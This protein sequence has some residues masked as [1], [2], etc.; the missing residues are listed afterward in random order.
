MSTLVYCAGKGRTGTFVIPDSVDTVMIYAFSNCTSLSKISIGAN[1]M[2]F[3]PALDE[4]VNLTKITVSSSNSWYTAS[5]DMLYNKAKTQLLICPSGKTGNVSI[6]SGVT[7][8]AYRSFSG[9]KNLSGITLPSSVQT[10]GEYAFKDCVKLEELELPNGMESL[11]TNALTGCTGLTSIHIPATLENMQTSYW[12]DDSNLFEGCTN[13]KSITVDSGNPVYSA[14]KGILYNK[15]KTKLLAYP[16]AKAGAMKIPSSVTQIAYGAF[17]GC[18]NLTSVTVPDSVQRIGSN[19][20]SG[21]VSL[22][23]VS[24]P[25]NLTRI[26]RNAFAGCENLSDISIPSSVL[27][28]SNYAFKDC[29]KL[30][31]ISLPSNVTEVAYGTFSGCESLAT[32]TLPSSLMYIETD[33]FY[34]CKSLNNAVI[35]KSVLYIG[36]R[37]FGDCTK[38]KSVTFCGDIPSNYEMFKDTKTTAYYPKGN[39]T[40]TAALREEMGGDITWKAKARLSKPAVTA[41]YQRSSGKP[42]LSWNAISKAK[43]YDIYRASSKNGTYKKIDSTTELTYVD[44]SAEDGKTYYYKVRAVDKEPDYSSAYSKVVSQI[45]KL[46]RPVVKASNEASTGEVKLTWESISGAEKYYIYRATSKN[47]SYKLIATAKDAFYVDKNGS[48]GKAYYYRVKAVHEKTEANSALSS[49]IRAVQDMKCPTVEVKLNS[50]SQPVVE[51]EKIDGAEK[52]VIYR[53]TSKS[54]EYKKIKTT[55]DTSFKDT[56]AN[57]GKTYYYKVKAI[58]SIS[59]ANSAWSPVVKIKIS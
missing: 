19:T 11:M 56:D 53:A 12:G 58:H 47:G 4:C 10:I 2:D 23:K 22:E 9:C 41:D 57:T 36:Q 49:V 24:L 13:L 40:W 27:S 43:Q 8:I 38:L 32:V 21:C 50:A 26:D 54:G 39:D 16:L 28:I 18:W 52:Y 20:F 6:P 17:A 59:T 34:G 29:A 45:S 1:V 51:W 44:T 31:S 55:T 37:V 46:T 48:V 15:G 35:P 3:R 25:K 30:K 33:A 14:S 42:I 7:Q 5:N